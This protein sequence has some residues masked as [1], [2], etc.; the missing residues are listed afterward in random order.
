M[1]AEGGGTSAVDGGGGGEAGGGTGLADTAGLGVVGFDDDAVRGDL[2]ML[3]HAGAGQD[4]RARDALG[5]QAVE[6][7]GGGTGQQDFLGHRQALVDVLL[8]EG[9]GGEAGID[10][11]FGTIERA[12]EGGPFPVGLD[13]GA[14]VVVGG[15]ID[16]V[17]EAGGLLLGEFVADEGLAAH[18]GAPEEG[19]DGVQH[20]QVDVLALACPLARQER[21]G[22]GLGGDHAG[23]LVGD[24]GA[25]QAGAF[26][27]GA[28]LDA[29]EAG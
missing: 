11:P 10:Q 17:D 16:Q 18:V 27:V 2:R 26:L 22:D 13:R 6:P 5:G 3:D 12:G 20:R 14:D 25:D 8:A 29:G 23:Q 4:G 9:R 15:L 24:D 7:L 19:H 28:A 1:F 21:G